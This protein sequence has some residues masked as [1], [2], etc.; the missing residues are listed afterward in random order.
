M[1]SKNSNM[2]FNCLTLFVQLIVS[3]ELATNQYRSGTYLKLTKTSIITTTSK[4]RQESRTPFNVSADFSPLLFQ[5]LKEWSLVQ[6]PDVQ[7][8]IFN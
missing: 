1:G 4:T 6:P 5:K 3:L 7:K 8:D 2:H